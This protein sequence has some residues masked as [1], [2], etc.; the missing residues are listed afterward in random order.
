MGGRDPYTN[1]LSLTYDR[2]SEIH[3]MAVLC[4]AA[5]HGGL[6]KKESGGLIRAEIVVITHSLI[7]TISQYQSICGATNK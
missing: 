3:L 2:T 4:V 5:E 1:C 7:R 6:M